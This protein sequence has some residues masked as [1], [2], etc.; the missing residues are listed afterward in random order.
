MAA[1]AE[2]PRVCILKIYRM[3]IF[4][5]YSAKSSTLLPAALGACDTASAAAAAPILFRAPKT[6]NGGG[7]DSIYLVGPLMGDRSSS[8]SG[9]GNG[10]AEAM[11]K[12][13]KLK[14]RNAEIGLF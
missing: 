3:V 4:A 10:S 2:F 12:A 8:G 9:G 6:A 14:S 7:E 11:P 13:K 5:S 1:E